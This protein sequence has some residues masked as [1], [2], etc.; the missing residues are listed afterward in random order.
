MSGAARDQ[1]RL[2]GFDARALAPEAWPPDRRSAYLL[3]PSVAHPLSTDPLV[4]PR[5]IE[6][7]ELATRLVEPDLARLEARLSHVDPRSYAI[8]ALSILPVPAYP[9]G[10]RHLAAPEPPAVDDTWTRLG[11]DVSDGALLSGLSN[12]GYAARDVRAL[13]SVWEPQLNEHHLFDDAAR[14]LEFRVL[15]E[16]R[17]PEHAP[18]F[19]FGLLR[20]AG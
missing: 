9:D 10:L 12:S 3:R 1:E 7:Q 8:V 20:A 19:V 13:R 18:F 14:A 6:D 4:W 15:A 2:L 17:V 16:R 11:Y 5:V